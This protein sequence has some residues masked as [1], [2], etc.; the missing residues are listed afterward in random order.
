MILFITRSL[1]KRNGL[2]IATIDI[3]TSL[4]CIDEPLTVIT[5]KKI[6]IPNKINSFNLTKLK[7]III[8]NLIL[9][10]PKTKLINFLKE[11]LRKIIIKL[12]G[13]SKL[14]PNLIIV[15]EFVGHLFWEDIN[16]DLSGKKIFLI[17]SSPN[18]FQPPN[19]IELK[20]AINII[21]S[22]SNLVSVSKNCLISWKKLFNSKNQKTFSIPNCCQEEKTEKL[23]KTEKNFFKKKLNITDKKFNIVCIASIQPRKNQN[24]LIECFPDLIKIKPNIKLRLI[25]PIA[26]F[27]KDWASSLLNKI[28]RCYT[29]DQ[30]EYLGVKDNPL[31]YIYCSNLL[32]LPSISEAMPITILEAMA[33]KTPIIASNV[34][35]IPELIEDKKEGLLFSPYNKVKFIELFKFIVENPQ[36]LNR[37]AENAYKKYWST[38]CKNNQ[39]K[40]FSKYIN[41]MIN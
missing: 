39:I 8:P 27:T 9:N 36:N 41:D 25:G 31:E 5:T 3:L 30:I 17:N 38:F 16:V 2:D 7:W 37:Y 34:D 23:L 33:L 20:E 4:L 13:I 26:P 28:G 14:N 10:H 32:I 35:G 21:G 29:S 15:N 19:P 12:N 24:F 6:K 40:L 22:Y 1:D 18:F 11:Y